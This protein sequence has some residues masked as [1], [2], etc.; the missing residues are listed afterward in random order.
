VSLAEVAVVRP[1]PLTCQRERNQ[2]SACPR[3]NS[4]ISCIAGSSFCRKASRTR[5]SRKNGESSLRVL[6]LIECRLSFLP[7]GPP[8]C[9]KNIERAINS[10][11]WE[12]GE[13]LRV[14]SS[15]A[16]GL[17]APQ[18]QLQASGENC[19]SL[20][21][22]PGK[23]FAPIARGRGRPFLLFFPVTRV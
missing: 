10:R 19:Y 23:G 6:G 15:A 7:D 16:R 2:R 22:S 4:H 17:V 18:T 5:T 8:Q 1:L 21:T 12:V 11:Q 14:P 13:P 9:C 20:L 3:P